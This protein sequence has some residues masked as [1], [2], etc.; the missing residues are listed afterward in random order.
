MIIGD[1]NN[2]KMMMI[3]I[4]NKLLFIKYFKIKNNLF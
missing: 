3:N 2:K 4:I 1:N